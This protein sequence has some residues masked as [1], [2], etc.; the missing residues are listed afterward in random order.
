LVAFLPRY[1]TNNTKGTEGNPADRLPL[2]QVYDESS[3]HVPVSQE[4]AGTRL[5]SHEFRRGNS[6]HCSIISVA[7]Q[8]PQLPSLPPST[9]YPEGGLPRPVTSGHPLKPARN[10]PPFSIF[11]HFPVLGLIRWLIRKLLRLE[12]PDEEKK[13]QKEAQGR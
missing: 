1:A 11:D 2:W 4:S 3:Q 5:S 10:P 8:I 6:S 9:S 12:I 13:K 7:K